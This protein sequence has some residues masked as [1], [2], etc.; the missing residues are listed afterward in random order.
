MQAGSVFYI[1]TQHL[2]G[3]PA[4][5][6]KD[7][8]NLQLGAS[9][10]SIPLHDELIKLREMNT[11][12]HCLVKAFDGVFI[13]AQQMKIWHDFCC[14]KHHHQLFSSNIKTAIR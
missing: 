13:Q 5:A 9:L 10:Y 11:T 12:Q 6:D 1:D 14:T 8:F 4:N 3:K 2:T 7:Y